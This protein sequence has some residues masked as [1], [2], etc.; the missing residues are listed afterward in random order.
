MRLESIR[1]PNKMRLRYEIL[2]C[3]AVIA[4]GALAGFLAK[5]FDQFVYHYHVSSVLAQITEGFG[6]IGDLFAVWVFTATLAAVFSSNA[7]TAGLHAASYLF[8]M[9]VVYYKQTETYGYHFRKQFIIWSV[10]AVLSFFLGIIIW[11]AKGKG[12]IS[13]LLACAPAALCLAEGY[14]IIT[15]LPGMEYIITALFDLSAFTVTVLVLK[16]ACKERVLTA[17]L[18]FALSIPLA[19][20]YFF[21]LQMM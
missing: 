19:V 17:V 9:V 21:V 13:R 4:L 10:A 6:L 2:Y 11:Y 15:Y 7:L 14:I 8:S 18:A 5:F 16:K 1:K 12:K 20:V 3:L